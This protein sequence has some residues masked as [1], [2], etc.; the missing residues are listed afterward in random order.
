MEVIKIE[1]LNKNYGKKVILENINISIM[2]GEI[3][4]IL[5]KNGA[6]KTTLIKSILGLVAADFSKFEIFNSDKSDNSYLN[7]LSYLPE[8]FLFYSYYSV[9]GALEF[10]A[11][12]HNVASE[13]I[14][15]RIDDVMR[16]LSIFEIKD[17]KVSKISKG[18]L[19]RLDLACAIIGNKE[20]IILD[21]PFSGLDPIG[22]KDVRN[23]C[24]ELKEEGKTILF[25]SH[26]ISEVEKISDTLIILDKGKILSH[27]KIAEVCKEEK[28]EDFFYRLIQ[29]DEMSEK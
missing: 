16:K 10:Y 4:V 14:V 26:M 13:E 20:L 22:I 19:Q 8:K 21:E 24:L 7:K 29:A 9:K 28:L 2:K 25:N 17:K 12:M 6:G 3:A 23:L 18:Q 1:G 11:D 27:G 15:Q 5:G